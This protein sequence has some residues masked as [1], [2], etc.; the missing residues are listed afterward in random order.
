MEAD[1]RGAFNEALVPPMIFPLCIT[2]CSPA[3]KAVTAPP[4][5]APGRERRR[6]PKGLHAVLKADAFLLSCPLSCFPSFL[7]HLFNTCLL[8]TC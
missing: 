3:E 1:V 8:S 4:H 6:Y 5:Q 2:A 7:I